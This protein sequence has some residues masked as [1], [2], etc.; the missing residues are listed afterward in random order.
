MNRREFAM[1]GVGALAAAVMPVRSM[2]AAMA[3]STPAAGAG[4]DALKYVDPALQ[5][6]AR[7]TLKF[8]PITSIDAKVLK[9]MRGM[10]EK[11]AGARLPDVP[12]QEQHVPVGGGAPDVTVYVINARPGDRR[13]G[14]LHTHG[15]G[16][17]AGSAK[18]E[19]PRL[20]KLAQ[21]MDCI[22]VS[23]DYRLAPETTY[24]GSIEDNYA[25]LKWMYNRA[26][27]IGLDTT[28]IALMGE[29][30][31]GGHAARLA[32]T[33]RDRAEVPVA[34]QILIY[35][36]LDDRTGSTVKMP[37]RIGTLGWNAEAN[38]FGWRSFLGMAPGG[39]GV[40][41]AG[42]PARVRNLA[43]LPPAFI[44]VGGIDLFV[45]EDV[46]YARRL[47]EVGVPTELLV[48][49]G[50]YHGFDIIAADTTPAQRFTKAK[51]NALRRAFGQKVEL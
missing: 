31:G 7:E 30:A 37:G 33:A 13:P 25:G 11:F 9:E 2:T 23:V 14:I 21:E 35:P 3:A 46:D 48:V 28:R 24:T 45:S 44:G 6:A 39:A 17:I 12:V 10:S 20:Q 18:W 41:S 51:L 19:V 16:Y 26:A 47:N 27:Q 42:V 8:A 15:G 4:A 22:I 5:A 43:G 29:S 34:A 38:V 49:P 40:P 50:A 36:M 1:L 32:I